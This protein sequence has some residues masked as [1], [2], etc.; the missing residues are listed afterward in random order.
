MLTS[1]E[2]FNYLKWAVIILIGLTVGITL[3]CVILPF[4]LMWIFSHIAIV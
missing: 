1:E 4:I 3:I 2:S